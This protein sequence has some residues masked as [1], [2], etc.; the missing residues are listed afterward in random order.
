MLTPEKTLDDSLIKPLL[1]L[2]DN[3]QIYDLLM[4]DKIDQ[5]IIDLI[6]SG[7]K[8]HF[9]FP[10][11]LDDS[12]KATYSANKVVMLFQ[13]YS[14][15]E[16]DWAKEWSTKFYEWIKTLT[17]TWLLTNDEINGKAY[18]FEPLYKATLPSS[19]DLSVPNTVKITVTKGKTAIISWLGW[20]YRDSLVDLDNGTDS[21]VS[22]WSRYS[23]QFTASIDKDSEFTLDSS[24]WLINS[25]VIT[26][27]AK[28]IGDSSLI[29]YNSSR[30]SLD[31]TLG[32]IL[33]KLRLTTCQVL[34]KCDAE[35]TTTF[36]CNWVQ[37]Y[38]NELYSNYLYG[39]IL[40]LKY[41]NPLFQTV[42]T[43]Y[44]NVFIQLANNDYW[45]TK[46]VPTEKSRKFTIVYNEQSEVMTLFPCFIK[47]DFFHTYRNENPYNGLYDKIKL[48]VGQSKQWLKGKVSKTD[49]TVITSRLWSSINT[50]P[51]QNFLSYN[52]ARLKEINPYNIEKLPLS[53]I[54]EQIDR[55]NYGV[56][57]S[58]KLYVYCIDNDSIYKFV[59]YN[60]KPNEKD[61][62]NFITGVRGTLKRIGAWGD[63]IPFPYA[64]MLGSGN[65]LAGHW[66]FGQSLNIF[67][68]V[69]RA[70]NFPVRTTIDYTTIHGY[71]F[72]YAKDTTIHEMLTDGDGFHLISFA[73][74]I[75]CD[76][77]DAGRV[78][79][80]NPSLNQAKVK[81][82]KHID[83]YPYTSKDGRFIFQH[84][85]RNQITE[86]TELTLETVIKY[87]DI[88]LKDKNRDP[89]IS[90]TDFSTI[91]TLENRSISY[92]SFSVIDSWRDEWHEGGGFAEYGDV[93]ITMLEPETKT[94]DII[95]KIN[96]KVIVNLSRTL[97]INHREVERLKENYDEEKEYNTYTNMT[98]QE[99]KDFVKAQVELDDKMEFVLMDKPVNNQVTG[100]EDKAYIFSKAGLL[101]LSDTLPA[102]ERVVISLVPQYND[103]G[104]AQPFDVTV[105]SES[106]TYIF[107]SMGED[108]TYKDVKFIRRGK[109]SKGF[110]M[111]L[112]SNS[113]KFTTS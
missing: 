63:F 21:M 89:V 50:E 14:V 74:D 55:W 32:K 104:V 45:K 12:K 92:V 56:D 30:S 22:D 35:I 6:G 16:I 109:D 54:K 3:D 41:I 78:A 43:S 26:G 105:R 77:F 1:Y 48:D 40:A 46:K 64:T 19:L 67:G 15:Y 98:E 51:P 9:P 85:P 33:G 2:F 58:N 23:Q 108:N 87:V 27:E 53:S 84:N 47:N 96:K 25:C 81:S 65:S 93:R 20:T 60:P 70:A 76:L 68:R 62:Y 24:K 38:G 61:D 13:R 97:R 34:T 31:I 66:F 101:I 95:N 42:P 107:P 71:T 29:L 91:E 113:T 75:D 59:Y 57:F 11:V 100:L 111:K 83:F 18:G 49:G 4:V 8:D 110:D 72:T 88:Q 103:K 52:F 90:V 39:R 7:L 99:I 73:P 94:V 69:A 80:V 86:N 10:Y 102:K 17:R 37:R 5:R 79:Y 36:P 112:S 28:I 44:H 82:L 106:D